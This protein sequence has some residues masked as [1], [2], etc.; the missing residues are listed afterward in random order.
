[1]ILKACS[2]T[3]LKIPSISK[4]FH[5]K[6]SLFARRKLTSVI[7]YLGE[8]SADAQC[9][10]VGVIRVDGDLLGAFCGLKGP[11]LS[12]GV[13]RACSLHHS[14]DHELLRCDSCSGKLAAFHVALVS[15]LEGSADGDDPCGLGI[16]NLWYV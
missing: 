3:S 16:F 11:R 5:M 1:L 7:S 13:G 4:G 14:G 15:A 9:F 10:P 6:T 8:V 2:A 12:L